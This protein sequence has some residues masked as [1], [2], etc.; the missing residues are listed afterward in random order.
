MDHMCLGWHRPRHLRITFPSK[1]LYGAKIGRLQPSICPGPF[2]VCHLADAA[3]G[4]PI[5]P[6]ALHFNQH[7]IKFNTCF[8]IRTR[9]KVLPEGCGVR[10]LLQKLIPSQLP[11][12]KQL[13]FTSG[14]TKRTVNT[15]ALPNRG[16]VM[17]SNWERRLDALRFRLT[18]CQPYWLQGRS[19]LH[20]FRPQKSTDRREHE[21]T[22]LRMF[23]RSEHKKSKA[24]WDATGQS[25]EKR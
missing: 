3:A 10:Y 17:G 11:F 16:E 2:S 4:P 6:A 23:F 18:I 25:C 12:H 24:S 8:E 13:S 5:H 14:W 21:C 7:H 19:I 22:K 9:S 1:G 20:S 15:S